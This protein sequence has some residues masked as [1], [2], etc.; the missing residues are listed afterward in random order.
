MMAFVEREIIYREIQKGE[1]EKTSQ[2]V[3]ECFGEFVAPGYSEEGV[4]EFSKYVNLTAI[5]Q[6]LAKNHFIFLALDHNLLVGVIEV[7]NY[8]HI[9]LFFVRKGYQKKGIGKKLYKLAINKCKANRP[10]VEAVEVNSSPY[11]VSIYEKLGFV[12]VDVEQITNGIRYT[13]MVFKLGLPH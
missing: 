5:D 1:E 11:A 7:R 6:R 12:K 10:D 4:N 9:S 2:L 3:M 8:D 13:P